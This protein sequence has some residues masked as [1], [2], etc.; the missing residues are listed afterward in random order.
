MSSVPEDIAFDTF[1]N[2]TALKKS[3]EKKMSRQSAKLTV[4][5]I[6]GTIASPGTGDESLEDEEELRQ[7]NL[8]RNRLAASK[9]RQRKKEWMEKL[10]HKAERMSKENEYLKQVLNNLKEEMEFLKTQLYMHQK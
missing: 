9:C 4:S 2:S 3:N 5:H 7:K 10:A 6:T 8:E 1:M